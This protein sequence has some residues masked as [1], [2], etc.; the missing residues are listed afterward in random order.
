MSET[1]LAPAGIGREWPASDIAALLAAA[2]KHR[3]A[4]DYR[5]G[6]VAAREAA[7]HA[8]AAGDRA[9]GAAALRLLAAQLMRLGA[10]EEAVV[11]GREA[12]AVLEALGDDGGVCQVL[13]E[14]SLA[15]NDLGMHEEALAALADA[16]DIA[17]RLGD[18]GL[19]YW[20]HNRTGCVHGTMGNRE[21]SAA[22]LTKALT[23]TDGLDSDA[24]FCIL[25]NLGDNAVYEVARL[26]EVGRAEDAE[27]ALSEALGYITE[28]LGLAR[29]SGNPFREAIALDN[30]GMLLGLAGDFES[31]EGLIEQARTIAERQ[32]YD[33]LE[34][35]TWEHRARIRLMR[36]DYRAAIKKLHVALDRGLA[37]GEK[38]SVM[39]IHRQL[40]SAYEKVGDAASALAHYRLFHDLEREARNDVAAVRARMAVH[41]FELDNAR[42]DADTARMETEQHRLRA[43]ELEADNLSWQRQAT[44]DALTGLPN[45]RFADLRLPQLIAAG[46][47]C[48]ALADVDLFKGVNDRYGHPVGDEVLRRI[49]VLLRD[50]VR[51]GDLVARFGG[52]EFLIALSAIGTDDAWARCEALRAEIAAYP[53]AQ[54]QD[55][56]SVTISLGLAA[57]DAGV[58]AALAVADERLYEAKRSGR[59]RVVAG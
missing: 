19:L 7:A 43:A 25:N 10:L 51:E 48:V 17:Q 41:S 15:L 23:M 20:V 53:W 14:G 46:P 27:R 44:E 57:V 8:E 55:G 24:R 56:L 50:D 32:G 2:E 1:S 42:L 33:S 29:G 9:A 6:S 38:P 40:S 22:F 12:A 35:S 47:V 13:T 5:A 54:V 49:A 21:L 28:A 31:A 4:G 52:E 18:R 16:R 58:D 3:L 30:Y 59:N 34:S 37:I 36:G 45:R 39:E 11:A 26:R